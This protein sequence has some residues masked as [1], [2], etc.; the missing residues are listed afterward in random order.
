MHDFPYKLPLS[1]YH[2]QISKLQPPSSKKNKQ[3]SFFLYGEPQSL[4]KCIANKFSNTGD[5]VLLLVNRAISFERNQFKICCVD[6]QQAT[7][8][9]DKIK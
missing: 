5:I 7:T 8:S 1:F 9:L 4:T 2:L 3:F 6:Q